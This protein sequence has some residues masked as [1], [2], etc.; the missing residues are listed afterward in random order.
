M[1]KVGNGHSGGQAWQQD[2]QGTRMNCGLF[3]LALVSGLCS[4]AGLAGP[5]LPGAPGP[6]RQLSLKAGGT[7][8]R[9]RHH[10]RALIPA[11]P[12]LSAR[13]PCPP[14]ASWSPALPLPPHA[15]ALGPSTTTLLMDCLRRGEILQSHPHIPTHAHTHMHT[16]RSESLPGFPSLGLIP[17]R[18]WREH[19]SRVGRTRG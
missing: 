6:P 18:V 11:H 3:P 5:W 9:R 17:L 12:C 19:T 1:G 2:C 15:V 14:L 10:H 8:T 13:S 4:V 7:Q 16:Q